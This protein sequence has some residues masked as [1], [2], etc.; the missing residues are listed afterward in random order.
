DAPIGPFTTSVPAGSL[1]LLTGSRPERRLVAATLAGRLEPVAGRAQIAGH[2]LPSESS[3]V[4]RLVAMADVSAD[5]HGLTVGELL[6]ERIRLTGSGGKGQVDAWLRTINSALADVG[7]S[8]TRV[9][10][11]TPFS[12]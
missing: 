1:L 3:Q 2:P 12:A 5:A 10:T 6:D 8:R 4:R 9:E 11:G 7:E